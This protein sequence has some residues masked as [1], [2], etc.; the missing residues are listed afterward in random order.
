M[1]G[2]IRQGSKEERQ[3]IISHMLSL[4]LCAV[5]LC[6]GSHSCSE[7]RSAAAMSTPQHPQ[8]PTLPWFP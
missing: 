1:E 7:L 8:P 3:K 2:K 4:Y 6:A 5:W